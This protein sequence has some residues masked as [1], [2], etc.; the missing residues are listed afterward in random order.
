[1]H[2]LKNIIEVVVLFAN[3][4]KAL[5]LTIITSFFIGAITYFFINKCNIDRYESI[6]IFANQELNKMIKN[7]DYYFE[8]S[9]YISIYDLSDKELIKKLIIQSDR[10]KSFDENFG[11]IAKISFNQIKDLNQCSSFFGKKSKCKTK[12]L[13]LENRKIF[14]DNSIKF[15]KSTMNYYID[16]N[17]TYIFD[18]GGRYDSLAFYPMKLLDIR[19]NKFIFPIQGINKSCCDKE[20]ILTDIER[21]L[22]GG[23]GLGSLSHKLPPTPQSELPK[24]PLENLKYQ[25]S[26]IFDMYQN[27]VLR[28][29]KDV[30]Q[31][32]KL[33]ALSSVEYSKFPNL[34]EREIS[35]FT[36]KINDSP[37]LE[38]VIHK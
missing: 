9:I 5:I 37:T 30:E 14:E 20:M 15:N 2:I 1:M 23:R 27:T 31:F 24:I 13:D 17:Y 19:D 12:I 29:P 36:C 26:Q 11:I 28:N 3:K 33:I 35:S 4:S 16:N 8:S 22:S 6:N 32:W 7:S 18:S 21:G 38:E 25:P 34:F 10:N